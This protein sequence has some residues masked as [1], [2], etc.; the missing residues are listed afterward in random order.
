MRFLVSESEEFDLVVGVASICKENL[1]PAPNFGM[2]TQV[3]GKK[4][5]LCLDCMFLQGNANG[6]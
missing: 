6:M 1:I 5:K 2:Y 4:G 3:S